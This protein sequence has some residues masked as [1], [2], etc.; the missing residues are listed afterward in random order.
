[1]TVKTAVAG[2]TRRVGVDL[3]PLSAA[4]GAE[5]LDADLRCL[6]DTD[7]EAIRHAWL[8]HLLLVFRGQDLEPQR[9]VDIAR[10][11]GVPICSRTINQGKIKDPVYDLNLLPP[12][13]TAISNVKE[14]GKPIGHLGDAEVV[15]HSDHSY[16]ERPAAARMLHGAECPPPEAGGN[17]SFLNACAAYDDL[18]QE[19]KHQLKG[20]TIKHDNAIS[21]TM[22]VRDGA[23][24]AQ[25]AK[26]SPGPSH[27]IIS[28]HPETSHNSIFLGRRMRAYVNGLSID[29]SEAL[30]DEL[31][32][33]TTQ[34]RFCYEH[35]WA[36]GDLVLCA[37]DPSYRRMLY[38]AQVE[39]HRPFEAADALEHSPHPRYRAFVAQGGATR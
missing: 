15:W 19:R 24:T 9:I 21:V 20:M 31:W 22:E 6:T 37:F 11:F 16:V 33:H 27:P 8:E 5:V 4:L 12:E 1:M 7:F 26:D 39:G 36:P 23:D 29:E 32:R 30:L 17:T 3:R 18:P 25:S 28:T 35:R 13:I 14:D 34:A 38:A 2:T 10:H